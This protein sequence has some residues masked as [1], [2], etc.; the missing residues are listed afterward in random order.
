MSSRPF[1]FVR[2]NPGI[3]LPNNRKSILVQPLQSCL[4]W[5]VTILSS[6][7]KISLPPSFLIDPSAVHPPERV[8]E[9]LYLRITEPLNGLS[10]H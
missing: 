7:F 3:L 6:V 10:V 2:N 9:G 8:R 4:R 5:I 1:N